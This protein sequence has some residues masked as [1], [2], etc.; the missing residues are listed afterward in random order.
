MTIIVGS[1]VTVVVSNFVVV[2]VTRVGVIVVVSKTVVN[3]AEEV[4]VVLAARP[5]TKHPYAIFTGAENGH[6]KFSKQT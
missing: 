1:A 4:G 3:D 6:R 5:D 2:G